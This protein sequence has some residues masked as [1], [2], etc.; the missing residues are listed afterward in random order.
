MYLMFALTLP[1]LGEQ[2]TELVSSIP[3]IASDAKEWINNIFVKLSNL[4]LEKFRY[5]KEI[6]FF[7]KK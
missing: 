4:S 7:L 5:Y 1:S 3:K 2:I 6:I